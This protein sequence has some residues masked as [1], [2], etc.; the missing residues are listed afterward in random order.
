MSYIVKL[1]HQYVQKQANGT[2]VLVGSQ[3]EA[4]RVEDRET[5]SALSD[6]YEATQVRQV[7]R[8]VKLARKASRR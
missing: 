8:P 3:R 5:A 6:A 1:G 2:V 4:T 7:A